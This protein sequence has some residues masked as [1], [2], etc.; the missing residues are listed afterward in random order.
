MKYSY[1]AILAAVAAPTATM[2]WNCG[3]SYFSRPLVVQSPAAAVTRFRQRKAMMNQAFSRLSSPRY[4]ITDND[5]KFELAVDVP[6]VKM[7]DID[8][9]LD[10]GILMVSGRREATD[11]DYSFTSKF[12]QSFQLDPSIDVDKFTANLKNGVLIVSAPKDLK[13]IEENIRTIP[14]TQLGDDVDVEVSSTE[15]TDSTEEVADD[16]K[17]SSEAKSEPE[18]KS[19]EDLEISDEENA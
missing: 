14:I 12:S 10:D 8:I 5:E 7:E 15:T 11:S 17:A 9:S 1:P 18:S 4:E 6:G 16:V 3:P 13:R 19:D 2:A